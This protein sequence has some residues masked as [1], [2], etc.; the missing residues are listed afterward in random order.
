MVLER[1]RREDNILPSQS[2]NQSNIEP[3]FRIDPDLHVHVFFGY[4][5]TTQIGVYLTSFVGVDAR[6]YQ[7]LHTGRTCVR[8]VANQN[9]KRSEDAEKTRGICTKSG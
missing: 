2:I 9:L 8:H 5:A 3:R 6:I 1:Q 7:V 4:T